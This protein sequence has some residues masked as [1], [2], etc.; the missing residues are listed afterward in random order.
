MN[1]FIVIINF[2]NSCVFVSGESALA[3]AILPM[4]THGVVCCLSVV[5]H[6]RVGLRC[7]HVNRSKNLQ[8]Y[9]SYGT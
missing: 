9:V 3:L 4:A 8:L 5:C 7:F 2:T 1:K 6:N